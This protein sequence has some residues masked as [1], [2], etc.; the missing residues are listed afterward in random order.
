MS[1]DPAPSPPDGY[2]H[3][4][5]DEEMEWSRSETF[6]IIAI[7]WP[8]S[9]LLLMGFSYTSAQI[10]RFINLIVLGLVA[11]VIHEGLHVAAGWAFGLKPAVGIDIKRF[12]PY[13]T[14]YGQFQSRL[15]RAIIL[16]APLVVL[17]AICILT[18]F[19]LSAIGRQSVDIIILAVINIVLAYYDILDLRFTLN[20]PEGAKEFHRKGYEVDYYVPEIDTSDSAD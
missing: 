7:M 1:D 15:Q 17:S 18:V 19:I 3:Y 14:T 8:L 11:M 2:R 13:V 12:Q 4:N 20:L 5:P 9:L 16:S 10:G 6:E